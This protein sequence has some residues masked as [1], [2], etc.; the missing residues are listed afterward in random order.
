MSDSMSWADAEVGHAE[1]GDPGRTE[2]LVTLAAEVARRPAG[3]VL[4]ACATSASRGERSSHPRMLRSPGC[5]G[6]IPVRGERARRT[7]GA[8]VRG[9]ATLR[10]RWSASS[11]ALDSPWAPENRDPTPR[12][13]LGSAQFATPKSADLEALGDRG[14][15]VFASS[16]ATSPRASCWRR[17]ASPE[18]TFAIATSMRRVPTARV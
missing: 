3:T 10:A 13:R 14:R 11:A 5:F 4:Q 18:K 16:R 9:V 7:C 17:F 6:A 15:S 2:R 8:N 1:L 12:P